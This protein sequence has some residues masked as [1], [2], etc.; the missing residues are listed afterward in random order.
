MVFFLIFIF[1]YNIKYL[2]R[3][4][5]VYYYFVKSPNPKI[6]EILVHIHVFW[7]E[8]VFTRYVF[9]WKI[10]TVFTKSIKLYIYFYFFKIHETTIFNILPYLNILENNIENDENHKTMENT[11]KFKTLMIEK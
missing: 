10:S 8:D 11:C 5:I 4:T 6:Y 7:D 1:S 2:L 9:V 3:N